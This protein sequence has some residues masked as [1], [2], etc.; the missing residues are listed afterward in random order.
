VPSFSN[1]VARSLISPENPFTPGTSLPIDSLATKGKKTVEDEGAAPM[2]QIPIV[3]TDAD[4]VAWMIKRVTRS[5]RRREDM[6]TYT[7]FAQPPVP[8]SPEVIA[9]RYARQVDVIER[10]RIEL[11]YWE[12]L[13]AEKATP[14]TT[15]E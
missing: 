1:A 7:G 9:E 8:E 4:S 13:V 3:R 14:S 11:T 15:E 10:M 6:L 12:S 5:I 2:I